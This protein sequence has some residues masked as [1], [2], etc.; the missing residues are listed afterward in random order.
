MMAHRR[1][2]HEVGVPTLLRIGPYRFAIHSN[3]HPPPHVHVKSPGGRAAF[4]LG[5]VEYRDSTGYT[6]RELTRIEELVR[7]HESEFLRRW[8]ERFG[9]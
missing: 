7:R 1:H 8:R 4:L 9:G 3:D 2:R 6:R 5:P